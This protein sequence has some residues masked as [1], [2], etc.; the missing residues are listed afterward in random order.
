MWDFL[1]ENRIAHSSVV[2]FTASQALSSEILVLNS[3]IVACDYRAM[4]NFFFRPYTVDS[5]VTDRLTLTLNYD[6]VFK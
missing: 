4:L 1:A 5:K 3:E 2:Y 6:I